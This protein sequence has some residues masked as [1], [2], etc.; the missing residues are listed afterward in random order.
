M[1]IY[2]E[3]VMKTKAFIYLTGVIPD[4]VRMSRDQKEKL[5]ND[6]EFQGEK[7]KNI[8]C[9]PWGENSISN[10]VFL[11]I[12]TQDEEL[13]IVPQK[14]NPEKVIES[15]KKS[16]SLKKTAL[17]FEKSYTWVK[18]I[19]VKSGIKINSPG[20]AN[21]KGG[22]EY[23]KLVKYYRVGMRGWNKMEHT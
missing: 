5:F 19:L 20:G 4:K 15:Y 1:N 17:E 21:N 7:E 22:H 9:F 14:I 23:R 8:V 3:F 12:E 13:S 18:R 11:E 10:N 2:K 16:Q 6:P